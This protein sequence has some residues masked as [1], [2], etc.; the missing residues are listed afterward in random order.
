MYNLHG[1]T[2]DHSDVTADDLDNVMIGKDYDSPGDDARLRLIHSYRGTKME[3]QFLRDGG[4]AEGKGL[5]INAPS[6]IDLTPNADGEVT[7]GDQ[8]AVPKKASGKFVDASDTDVSKSLYYIPSGS[9]DI[10]TGD[11]DDGIDD[12]KIFLER[13]DSGGDVIFGLVNVIEVTLDSPESFDH[14]EYGVWAGLNDDG[15]MVDELGIGFVNALS[16]RTPTSDM[17]NFG[18]ANYSGNY[19]ANVQAAHEEGEGDVTAQT[20][21]ATMMADFTKATVDITLTNLAELEGTIA[22]NGFLG[23]DAD[24]FDMD[25]GM[26]G[27]QPGPGGLAEDGNFKGSFEGGFFG[28]GSDKVEEAGGVFSFTTTD[29]EDGAFV[30]AFGVTQDD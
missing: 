16:E 10:T 17:P 2:T 5:A 4:T 9:D 24:L 3:M 8:T 13:N 12:T 11:T 26:D 21:T 1:A 22:G 25:D 15:D 19:V 7:S 23:T 18:N 27:I 14:I 29:N 20:N 6:G 30:G 28:S